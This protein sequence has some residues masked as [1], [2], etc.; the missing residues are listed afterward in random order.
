[1]IVNETNKFSAEKGVKASRREISE[2]LRQL[3]EGGYAQSYLFPVGGS[4]H[5]QPVAYSED[6]AAELWFYLTPKGAASVASH[7]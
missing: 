5:P 6:R 1:M 7:S 3:I 2:V 4:G